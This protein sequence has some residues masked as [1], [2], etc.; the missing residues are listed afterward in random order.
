[1]KTEVIVPWPDRCLHPNARV[2]WSKRAK[3]AKSAREQANLLAKEAG[4]HRIEWPDGHLHV[5]IHGWPRDRRRRDC[6]GLLSSLKPVLDGIADAIGI[7]DQ[8]FVPHPFISDETRKPPMVRI[9]ISGGPNPEEAWPP[10]NQ[11]A[12]MPYSPKP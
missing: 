5:W 7:D 12:S 10:Q 4:L 6:D 2:H 1:M 3:A 9:R 8:R 11:M